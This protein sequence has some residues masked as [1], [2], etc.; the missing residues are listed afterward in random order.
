MASNVNLV[1]AAE[2]TQPELGQ[3]NGLSS[4]G[5][6]QEEPQEAEFPQPSLSIPNG[7][8]VAAAGKQQTPVA[9]SS[10]ETAETSRPTP[11]PAL[12]NLNGPGIS[13][14]RVPGAPA[15]ASDL[16]ASD[17]EDQGPGE[18]LPASS[19]EDMMG[20]YSELPSIQAGDICR[21]HVV[22]VTPNGVIVDIGSKTEGIVPIDDFFGE[23]DEPQLPDGEEIEVLVERR[24]APG[25]YAILSYKRARQRSLW[26]RIEA[27]YREKKTVE[28]RVVERVKGGLIVNVGLPAFLPGSQVDVRA[29]H[30]LDS[31]LGTTVP[32]RIIKLNKHRGNIVVSRRVLREEELRE[33]KQQ[34]MAKLAEGAVVE[35]AVKN[36]TDYGVFVD[37]G[38]IDG[39]IH[40]TDISWGRIQTPAEV[41]KPGDPV[42]AKVIK[43]DPEK[44]RVSLSIKHLT[45][46]PWEAISG[47]YHAGD[48]QTGT[49]TSLHDYGVFV[50]LATGVEGLIHVSETSW[51]KRPRHPSKV[52]KPGAAVEAVVLKVEPEGRR[53]SHSV[54]Q[55]KADPWLDL[56][57][58]YQIGTIVE[59]RVRS[60]TSYG[61]FMEVEEG[62]EG[63]VHVSDLSWDQKVKH[64]DEVLKKGRKTQ[65]VVLHVDSENRRLSLG[66]KQL[67]PDHWETF[68]SCYYEGDVVTGN[69]TRNVKFG[70]FVE[71]APGVEGLCH[72]SEMPRNSNGKGP[73]KTGQAYRFKIVKL[74]EFT[75]K[76]GLSRR[77]ISD[78]EAEP[79]IHQEVSAAAAGNPPGLS[80]P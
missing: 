72:S 3:N 28:G 5:V 10:A 57:Q 80:T 2:G 69:V 55:C 40:V 41:F 78:K 24:G 43:F 4:V 20:S 6:A 68:F 63:L 45:T 50:E 36:V 25:E 23:G 49:V 46:D 39:L 67:Q 18:E 34:T 7:D 66:I 30:D 60:L 47:R 62:V 44:E 48:T 12:P 11:E 75:K 54:K 73:L 26:A 77:G 37:L 35:G 21:G 29:A 52:F 8:A 51:S 61:A 74:D 22:S 42:T 38:G 53:I 58:R 19:Y 59:G 70:A 27:D 15:P 13:F 71:L 33:Q 56:N 1:P 31:L 32:V 79:V 16:D 65:A 14:S 9:P 64:P 17:T 76:I